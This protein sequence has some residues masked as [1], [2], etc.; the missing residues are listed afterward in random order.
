MAAAA[1]IWL[2][3]PLVLLVSLLA[4]AQDP[5][6]APAP[7]PTTPTPT[8]A[9]TTAPIWLPGYGP[10]QWSR[11]RGSIVTSNDAETTYTIFCAPSDDDRRCKIGGHGLL[12]PF[13]FAEGPSTLHYDHTV[14]STL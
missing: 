8:P 4:A 14:A 6:P 3:L 7:A 13:T 1:A 2:S 5:A 12:L 10:M 11:L 9:P